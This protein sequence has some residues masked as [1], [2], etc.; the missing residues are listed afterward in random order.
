MKRAIRA[1]VVLILFLLASTAYAGDYATLNFIGFSNDGKYFAFEEFGTQDGSGFP[2]STIYFVETAKNKFAVPPVKVRLDTEKASEA[3]ARNRAALQ[4]APLIKKFA[5]VKGHRGQL[6]LSHLITDLTDD[7][8]AMDGDT[9]TVRFAEVVSSAYRS[10]YHQLTLNKIKTVTKNCETYEL[11][12]F[13]IDLSLK[14]VDADTSRTLQKDSSLP[15]SRYCP[16]GYRIQDVYLYK[17]NISVFL[18]VFQPGF[19]GPDMRYLAV[20]GKLK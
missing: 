7:K 2:Y 9:E 5:I 19:E 14:D 16:I 8:D 15:D 4:A 1:Y 18:N 11:D 3:A 20:S 10:G 12:N 17:G 6:V 13:L